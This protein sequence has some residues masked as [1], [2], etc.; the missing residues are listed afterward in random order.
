MFSFFLYL[1]LIFV[2]SDAIEHIYVEVAF[3]LINPEDPY[4]TSLFEF[5]YSFSIRSTLQVH[6]PPPHDIKQLSSSLCLSSP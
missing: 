6:D 1:S 2:A 3:A 4:K 5:V